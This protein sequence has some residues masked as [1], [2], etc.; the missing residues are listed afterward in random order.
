MATGALVQYVAFRAEIDGRQ[1]VHAA[2]DFLQILR[3]GAA[4]HAGLDARHT[5]FDGPAHGLM[6]GFSSEASEFVRQPINISFLVFTS[7]GIVCCRRL[8]ER[9]QPP[10]GASR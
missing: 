3:Q 5:L 9:D 1:I 7:H 2:K 4:A 10:H 6:D 8:F